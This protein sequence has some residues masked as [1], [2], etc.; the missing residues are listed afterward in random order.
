MSDYYGPM[1]EED[2][3]TPTELVHEGNLDYLEPEICE[4]C[5]FPLHICDYHLG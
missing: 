4:V 5:E 1:F 2:Y 3:P